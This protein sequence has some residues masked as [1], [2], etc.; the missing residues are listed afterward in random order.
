MKI[1]SAVL[2]FQGWEEM[3]ESVEE[4]RHLVSKLKKKDVRAVVVLERVGYALEDIKNALLTVESEYKEARRGSSGFERDFYDFALFSVIRVAVYVKS[5]R[6][7]VQDVLDAYEGRGAY[8]E[9]FCGELP[10]GDGND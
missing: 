3:A 6:R 8:W 10:S 5:A 7:L 4:L 1:T 9:D 2:F